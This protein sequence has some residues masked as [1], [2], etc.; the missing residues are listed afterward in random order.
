MEALGRAARAEGRVYFTG[1]TTALLLGWRDT[2]IDIDVK[3]VPEQDAILRAIPEIKETLRLNVE[4]AAPD[5]FI[6]PL[7]G[8]E[9]RSPFIDRHGLVSFHH[10]DFYAQALAKIERGHVVDLDDVREMIHRGLVEEARATSFFLAIEPQLHR[11][12]AIDAARFRHLV[13]AAFRG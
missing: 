11:Y 6:P 9:D 5:Q 8:W 12:P 2:T 13:Q 1:G 4:L 3:I 7:P 10:Y